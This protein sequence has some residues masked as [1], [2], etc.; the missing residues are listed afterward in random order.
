MNQNDN[1]YYEHQ[2]LIKKFK[3]LAQKEI[4]G[5]RIFD[6]HV[7]KFVLI[8]FIILVLKGKAKLADYKKNMIAINKKGMADCYALYNSG[9]FLIHLELEFK[10][11]N[12]NQS[13]DQKQW[14]KI[15]E[16][17]GGFYLIIR[18]EKKAVNDIKNYLKTKGIW[19]E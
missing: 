5:I 8:R 12:A 9:K 6:R 3:L 10:T 15:I 19:N 16:N 7:G 18:N 14:Q 11:G 4:K 1:K 2:Q 17:M 13:P